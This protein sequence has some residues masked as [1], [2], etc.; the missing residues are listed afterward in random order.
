VE[1]KKYS[2]ADIVVLTGLEAVRK[3]PGMYIGSTGPAGVEHLI[4][5]LVANSIDQALVSSGGSVHVRIWPDDSIEVIDDGPGLNLQSDRVLGYFTQLH[6]TPTADG[7]SPHVH[8][9]SRGVGIAVAVALCTRFEVTTTFQGQQLQCVW[10]NGGAD[11]SPVT[12]V[13]EPGIGTSVRM[14]LDDTI[15]DSVQAE[16]DRLRQRM[17]QLS[18]LIP[19]LDVALTMHDETETWDGD[20]SDLLSLMHDRVPSSLHPATAMD[21]TAGDPP[22]SINITLAAAI[23]P[24]PHDQLTAFLNFEHTSEEGDF[25]R[26]LRSTIWQVARTKLGGTAPNEPATTPIPGLVLVASVTMLHPVFGGPTRRRLDDPRA[27]AAVEHLA[28]EQLEQC[29]GTE[30]SLEDLLG[31]FASLL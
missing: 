28:H 26:A 13:A 6:A 24:E 8:L 12:T 16:P 10:T 18:A 9:A 29:I 7:H 1:K 14:W 17:Q 15:F 5:E 19:N 27:V 30:P 11:E 2:A 3:R 20:L 25:I 31:S 4:W 21:L 22:V 23:D